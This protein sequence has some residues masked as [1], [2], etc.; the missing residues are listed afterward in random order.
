MKILITVIGLILISP[1]STAGTDQHFNIWTFSLFSTDI[2]RRRMSPFFDELA[3]KLKTYPVISPSNDIGDLINK[4]K[5]HYYKLIIAPDPIGKKVLAECD[6]HLTAI[7]LQDIH[8]Y[9]SSNNQ[10]PIGDLKNI[11]IVKHTKSSKIALEELP[12]IIPE[13]KPFLYLNFYSLVKNLNS[14][15]IDGWVGTKAIQLQRK[16]NKILLFHFLLLKINS[17]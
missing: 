17:V 1:A 4:C 2:D 3:T 5:K 7:T 6:Y 14:Q 12:K 16:S 8:L 10:K 11:G 13:F 15:A 9:V